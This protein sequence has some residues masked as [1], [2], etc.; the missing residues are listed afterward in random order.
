MGLTR[1]DKGEIVELCNRY[2]LAIDDDD[3]EAWLATWTDDGVMEAS[4][5]TA[6]GKDNLRALQVQL[7]HGLSTGKRH[8]SVNHVVA[9]AGDVAT[10]RSYFI[11]F[12]RGTNAVVATG[13][14]ADD[15]R[16]VDGVWAFARRT[17]TTDPNWKQGQGAR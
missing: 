8:V 3:I 2:A 11:I 12:D 1:D 7:E 6:R 16:R 4:F 15:L 10:A 5:G 17:L 13:V 9:D 14:V